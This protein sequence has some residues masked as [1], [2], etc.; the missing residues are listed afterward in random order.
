MKR[1]SQLLAALPV[2]V[3][4]ED[5]QAVVAQVALANGQGLA[6]DVAILALSLGDR[7][8]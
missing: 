1:L 3:G 7:P 5:L 4:D 2:P 6:D 8:R